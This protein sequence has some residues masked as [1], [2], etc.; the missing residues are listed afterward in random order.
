MSD[1][2]YVHHRDFREIAELARNWKPKHPF[3]AHQSPIL[4]GDL[5][6]KETWLRFADG[7]V[8]KRRLW[9]PEGYYVNDLDQSALFAL[10]N[11]Y[12]AF[13]DL[14]LV[15]HPVQWLKEMLT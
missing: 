8:I 2:H 10:D 1:I 15:K 12:T 9:V 11:K 14:G 4:E 13:E 6:T 7:L 3:Q 5:D